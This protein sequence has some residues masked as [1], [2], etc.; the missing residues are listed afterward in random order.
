VKQ[1]LDTRIESDR[2]IN[3][4]LIP[5]MDIVGQNF[6][7]GQIFVPEMLVSAMTMKKALGV[8]KPLMAGM[9][10]K[11]QGR[12]MIATVQ[13]DLHD[14]GKNLVAMMLEGAGFEVIDLGVNVSL[15]RIIEEVTSGKPKILALSSLLTT[16]MPEMRNTIKVLTE[17]GLRDRLRVMV[18]G[19]PI[20]AKFAE[21][22]GADGFGKDAGEA[23]AL[24][25]KLVS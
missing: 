11:S 16:T 22:I 3:E 15:E 23:V 17:K 9:P 14:I 2:L 8:L 7:K 24:A 6:S 21:S 1:A 19:A 25:R 20:D 12:I 13:G 10:I 18:G 4:G 5:A